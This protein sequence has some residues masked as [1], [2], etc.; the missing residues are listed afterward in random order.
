LDD[1]EDVYDRV[2]VEA[3]CFA[4]PGFWCLISSSDVRLDDMKKICNFEGVA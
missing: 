2:F 3:S 4:L 1:V